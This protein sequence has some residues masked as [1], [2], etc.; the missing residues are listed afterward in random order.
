MST[1]RTDLCGRVALGLSDRNAPKVNS[2]KVLLDWR[3]QISYPSERF[4]FYTGTD[5]STSV[6]ADFT[7]SVHCEADA[8]ISADGGY[9]YDFD[10]E[11]FVEK[12]SKVSYDCL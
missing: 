4:S 5:F 2:D 6:S 12:I 10:S 3:L 1:H 9:D 8:T 7:S 11:N